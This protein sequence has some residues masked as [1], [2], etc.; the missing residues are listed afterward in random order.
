MGALKVAD[1]PPAAPQATRIRNRDS[2]NPDGLAHARSERRPDLNDRTFS[3]H[4]AAD[5]DAH[6]RGKRLDQRHLRAD[7]TTVL[8]D[9]NHYF[10][11]AVAPCFP[12]KTLDQRPVE[13]T[14][15]HG[16]EEEEPDAEPREM[17]APDPALLTELLVARCYPG[18]SEYQP[19][20]PDGSE[21]CSDS[22][23]ERQ[24]NR[25]EPRGSG[26]RC[27]ALAG[28]TGSSPSG[29]TRG[30]PF[31]RDSVGHWSHDSVHV[32]YRGVKGF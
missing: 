14:A 26:P 10:G 23:D 30:V 15:E 22:D 18:K 4:R 12:G 17:G 32:R 1:M 7:T 9:G 3:P 8:R 6:S 28:P 19:A 25:P 31:A 16:D 2:E 24:G 21:A 11:D 5:A 27:C 20:E 13:E 29:K